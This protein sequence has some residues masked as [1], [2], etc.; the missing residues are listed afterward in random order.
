MSP[1]V[2][3]IERFL[4]G[5]TLAR[6]RDEMRTA[7]GAAATVLGLGEGERVTA[8]VRRATE[9]AVSGATRAAIAELLERA[10]PRIA[11]HFGRRLDA[12]EDPQFLRYVTGDYFVA[13]QDGNTPVIHDDTRFR[14]VSVVIFLSDPA[15]DFGGGALL[16]HG[17][18]EFTPA[19][20]TLV[21]FPSEATHEVA[22]VSEGERLTIVSWYRAAD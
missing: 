22:P 17:H 14:K 4:D 3:E 20:G 13:H 10:R 11:E 21:A 19:P 7:A 12:C 9:V 1:A 8:A 16:L 5:E 15:A 2:L 18:G 6:V